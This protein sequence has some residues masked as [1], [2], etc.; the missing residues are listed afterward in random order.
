MNR[1]KLLCGLVAGLTV[2]WLGIWISSWWGT[3]TL[4]FENKPLGRVLDSFTRQTQLPV[5]T[6]LNRAKPITIRVRRVTVTEALEAIQASAESRGG[7]L[8][9]LLAPDPAGLAQ[10]R[11]LL[12]RPTEDSG[13]RTLEF[14]IPFPAMASLEELPEWR[15]PRDQIWQP[16]SGLPRLLQPTAENAA[17]AAEVRI[18]LPSDWNP[19]LRQAP[20]GGE[21]SSALTALAK[22]AGG[23]A[24]MV[25]LLPAPRSESERGQESSGEGLSGR[26]PGRSRAPSLPPEKW[27][28]RLGP[29]LAALPKEEQASLRAS[30]QETAHQFQ[31]WESLTPEQRREKM[32]ALMENPANAERMSDR[33]SR[34]MRRLSP[35]QRSR[36]YQNYV[37]RR[38][39]AKSGQKP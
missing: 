32:Q 19:P 24:E 14:R 20:A 1:P 30:I 28:E 4:E 5:F 36:R 26:D 8:A 2:I 7:R 39:E 21:I 27:I 17:E 38:A 18:L 13:I 29:R 25:F 15:D 35:E 33:F 12:P 37:E 6:D 34:G 22:M 10:I 9:F 3:V 23:K 31:D 11:G 16:N